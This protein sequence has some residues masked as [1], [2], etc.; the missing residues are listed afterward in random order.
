[1][2]SKLIEQNNKSGLKCGF[3]VVQ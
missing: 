2:D 3:K 1:M